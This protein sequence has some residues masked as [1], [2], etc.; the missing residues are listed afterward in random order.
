[1]VNGGDTVVEMQRKMPRQSFGC[2]LADRMMSAF[3]GERIMN[4]DHHPLGQDWL[5][6]RMGHQAYGHMRNW[7][8]IV[9]WL[10]LIAGVC[11]LVLFWI[12]GG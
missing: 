5:E 4:D 12:F 9:L 7:G 8:S 2:Q 10:V 3:V 6:K 11:G 1:M